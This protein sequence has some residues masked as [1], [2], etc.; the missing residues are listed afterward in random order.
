MA[1]NFSR[2]DQDRVKS[3][4]TDRFVRI[5]C[6]PYFCGSGDPPALSLIDGFR[7]LVKR[8]TRFHLGENHKLTPA[9]DDVD[10]TKWASPAPRQDAKS[11]RNQK[12]GG[13]AFS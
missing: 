6:E 5:C 1:W 12:Y 10:L 2:R 7:G 11:L 8:G 3:K 4:I 9:R 13:P